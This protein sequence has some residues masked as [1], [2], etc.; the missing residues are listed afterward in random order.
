LD[1]GTVAVIVTAAISIVSALAG[2]RYKQDK[3]KV[4]KLLGDVIDAVQDNEVSEEECQKIAADAKSF[5][6]G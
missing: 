1:A 2:V 6:E 5:L 3:D 4:T